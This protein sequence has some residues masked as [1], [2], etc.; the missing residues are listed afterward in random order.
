MST[1]PTPTKG[2]PNHFFVRT[3]TRTYVKKAHGAPGTFEPDLGESARDRDP[4]FWGWPNNFK[5]VR[6]IKVTRPEWKARGRVF[7]SVKPKGVDIDITFWER[8]AR[9]GTKK[10]AIHP[11]EFRIG[12]SAN[13]KTAVPANFDTTSLMIVEQVPDGGKYDY[14]IRFVTSDELDYR[15]FAPYL[16]E[17]APEHQYGY[18]P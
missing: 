13:A 1:N 14:F 4:S 11:K 8:E 18:G 6:H 15:V 12:L 7:S 2:L 10:R 16:K 3:L 17:D 9:Q 5:P